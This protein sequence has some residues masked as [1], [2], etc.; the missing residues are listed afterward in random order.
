MWSLWDVGYSEAE[1][2]L[3]DYIEMW[4][5]VLEDNWKDNQMVKQKIN[6]EV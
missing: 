2:V 4:I 3:Y 5:G 6:S 1:R